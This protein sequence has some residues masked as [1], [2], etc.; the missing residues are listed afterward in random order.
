MKPC[1]KMSRGLA[2]VLLISLPALAQE[3]GRNTLLVDDMKSIRK[4]Q[5]GRIEPGTERGGTLKWTLTPGKDVEMT[6]INL[7]PFKMNPGDYDRLKFEYRIDGPCK[8]F[9]VKVTHFAFHEGQQVIYRVEQPDEGMGTWREACF[10]VGQPDA[11]WEEKPKGKPE[12]LCLRASCGAAQPCVIQAKNLRFVKQTVKTALNEV[13]GKPGETRY[14]VLLNNVDAE[15][16]DVDLALDASKLKAFAGS[17]SAPRVRIEPG[18]SVAVAV[19]LSPVANHGKAPLYSESAEVTVNV[20]GDPDSAERLTVSATIPLPAL[21]R[22]FVFTTK[23]QIANAKENIKKFPW[24]KKIYDDMMKRSDQLLALPNEIPDRAGNWAHYYACKDCGCRLKTITPT[25]HQCTNCGKMHTGDPYD[26]VVIA[27]VHSRWADNARLLG[28]AYAFTDK[29]EYAK[30]SASIFKEYAEKYQKYVP[31]DYRGKKGVGWKV[32]SY[33]LGQAVWAIPIAQGYDFIRDA[34]VLT[35]DEKRLIENDFLRDVAKSVQGSRSIHN[36]TCWRNAAV[37]TIGLAIGDPK[38]VQWAIEEPTGLKEEIAQGI[39]EDGFWFEGSWGYHFYALSPLCYLSESAGHVGIDVFD[40]RFERMFT[41]PLQFMTA[42]RFLPA[43]NDSGAGATVGYSWCYAVAHRHYPQNKEIAWLVG[44]AI[45]EGKVNDVTSLLYLPGEV[46]AEDAPP[47]KTTL[48]TSSGIVIL[49]SPSGADPIYV[50]LEYGPHGGGHGHPDKL[51]FVLCAL[52]KELAPDAGSISYAVPLHKQWYRQTLSHSTLTVDRESQQPTTGE[53]HYMNSS[54]EFQIASVR[55]AEAYPGVIYDR[56]MAMIGSE[57][58]LVLDN[59][60]SEKEHLYDIA[61]HVRG[62]LKADLDLQP[63][64]APVGDKN[65]YEILESVKMAKG[66]RPTTATFALKSDQP[67]GVRMLVADA[68]GAEVITALGRGNPPSE[69]VPCVILRR[70]AKEARYLTVLEPF[71]D[72]PKVRSV[73]LHP[74]QGPDGA[75]DKDAVG[76]AVEGASWRAAGILSLT[77][78]KRACPEIRIEA[79]AKSALVLWRHDALQGT[80]M[81]EGSALRVAGKTITATQ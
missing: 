73:V 50:A 65:G 55:T 80:L 30:R 77:K 48:F 5:G 52:G 12:S 29:I 32:I 46:K 34:G 51:G 24:A 49:R 58:V 67:M 15:P 70:Q 81:V 33:C 72:Q 60:K 78:A 37:G 23:E 8:W 31:E 6:S 79:D 63:P 27:S 41:A 22:P 53:L 21:S 43:F 2:F 36:I 25:Q 1:L 75:E 9:G 45:A 40:R 7:A 26:G 74:V 76:F 66:L 16:H 39:L 4:W 47:M 59:V 3:W 56:T 13:V 11:I 61:Y 62:E 64:A 42:E 19:A 28:L 18:K 57:C 69:R 68:E 35:D 38:L 71:R 14:E 10:A 54:P 17:L 44:R 20:A